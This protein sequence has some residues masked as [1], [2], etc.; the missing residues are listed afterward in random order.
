VEFARALVVVLVFVEI[1]VAGVGLC[2]VEALVT[3][4]GV[5]E[6]L[7]VFV[8]TVV[9]DVDVKVLIVA[10]VVIGSEDVFLVS[11]VVIR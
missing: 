4:V 11:C 3:F 1:G 7:V 8:A 2:P 6:E 9:A 10:V 5:A